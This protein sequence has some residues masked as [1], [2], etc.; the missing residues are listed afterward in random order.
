MDKKELYPGD[1]HDVIDF[2]LPGHEARL[3]TG[4][5]ALEGVY[6]NKYRWIGD[7]VTAT[8]RPVTTAPQR[9]RIRGHAAGQL[10]AQATKP[11]IVA[12]VNGT[13]VGEWQLDRTGLFILEADV[14]AASEY[15]IAIEA[16]PVWQLPPDERRLTVTL[17]ML[18]LT[19]RD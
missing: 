14:P 2:T 11:R 7:H 5:Y 13:Q 15:Q 1:R 12:S 16:S 4:W 9:L 18:R 17:S 6:G 19:P 10:F 8:L 3:G